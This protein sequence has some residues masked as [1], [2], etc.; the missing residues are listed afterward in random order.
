[1]KFHLVEKS[2]RRA[3]LFM[4]LFYILLVVLLAVL[5][6]SH[7]VNVQSSICWVLE[8]QDT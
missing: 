6:T 1:M 3:S 2:T 8:G 5:Y 4:M 7:R